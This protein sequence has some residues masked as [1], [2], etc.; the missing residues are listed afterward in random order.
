MPVI[1]PLRR[2]LGL[3]AVVYISVQVF[4]FGTSLVHHTALVAE[5]PGYI[6]R[7]VTKL[8]GPCMAVEDYEFHKYGPVGIGKCW[9]HYTNDTETAATVIFHILRGTQWVSVTARTTT[10]GGPLA[11]LNW[12]VIRTKENPRY[13]ATVT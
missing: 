13:S 12:R 6:E 11:T 9:F 7:D 10:D 5:K 3:L 2:H 4:F 8:G 1:A